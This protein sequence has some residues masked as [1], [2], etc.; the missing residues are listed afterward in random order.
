MKI[1]DIETINYREEFVILCLDCSKAIL[2]WSKISIGGRSA[3]IVEPSSVFQVALLANANS[4]ILAHNHP[5]EHMDASS[6][7][8][9]LTK[10]LKN[11]GEILG[12]T[13]DDHLIITPFTFVSMKKK[14]LF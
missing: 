7:D 11:I 12:V 14:Q 4:I 2:G 8:I 5:S 3:T 6:A 9:S 13:I 10:R 1:W